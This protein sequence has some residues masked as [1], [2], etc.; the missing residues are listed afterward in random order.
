MRS[1]T[2]VIRVI[3][4]YFD[5]INVV[6]KSLFDGS[7]GSKSNTDKRLEKHGLT[8][9]EQVYMIRRAAIESRERTEI[10]RLTEKMSLETR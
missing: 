10:D 7:E 6:G 9:N 5:F 8:F 2:L 1:N 4:I 3:N